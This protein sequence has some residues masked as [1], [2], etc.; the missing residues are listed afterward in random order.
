MKLGIIGGSGL[1]N[2]DSIKIIDE[3]AIDTP[4]GNP[5]G[6]YIIGKVKN[7][8]IVFLPRH[9]DGHT[10]SPSEINH[11]ANIFGMKKLGVTHILA[12]SAVG[13]LKGDLPPK[14]VVLIDQY[15]DRTKQIEKHTFFRSGIAA[16]IPF[17][18]P[19]C[20][21]FKDFVFKFAEEAIDKEYSDINSQLKPK[22]VKNGTYV[23]MEGP[24]FSTK[25]ESKL[26]KS[27]GIDVVGMTSLAEAKLSREAE[28]C[29]CTAAM[30]T[31]FDSW[32]PDHDNVTVDMVIN[33]MKSNIK[34]AKEIVIKTAKNFT[35]FKTSCSC[36]SALK[37]AV[38]TSPEKIPEKI[39]NDLK[40][41]IGK[42]YS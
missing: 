34:V 7:T 38:M 23:N 22:A 3:V 41:I 11:R 8:D 35:E 31:D 21:D 1:Y 30:V 12:I 37:N 40:P 15:V 16:H 10:I 27:W 5:S 13:S 25:A 29:Y 4:F 17:G 39:K 2:I 20:N 14:D 42:Y 18:D 6:N 19:I 9:G 24:A 36:S 26:Y 28:I 33:T 32:H